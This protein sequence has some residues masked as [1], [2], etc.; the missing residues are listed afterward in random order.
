MTAGGVGLDQTSFSA[1]QRHVAAGDY[2]AAEA[3]CAGMAAQESIDPSFWQ[4]RGVIASMAQ[5]WAAAEAHFRWTI[6][7]A[8]SAPEP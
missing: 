2:A 6:K 3:L 8:P 7:L 4:L 1:I 5:D